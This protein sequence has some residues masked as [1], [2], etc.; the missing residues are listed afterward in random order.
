MKQSGAAAVF[1][2]L[3]G[4]ERCVAIDGVQVIG[5][6]AIRKVLQLAAKR[7]GSFNATG[8]SGSR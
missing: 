7:S 1:V 5:D 4:G 2:H 3:P 8:D 6:V